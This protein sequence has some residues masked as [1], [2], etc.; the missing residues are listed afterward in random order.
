LLG[1]LIMVVRRHTVAQLIGWLIT[2]N[3]V[4]LG[5]IALVATF[6]FIVEAG[7]FLDLVAAVLIMVVF[8]SGITHRLAEATSAELMELRG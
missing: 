7:V 1:A 5:A 4:F 8:V 3:G 2:E 6:P